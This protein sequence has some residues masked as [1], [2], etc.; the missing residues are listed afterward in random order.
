M[1]INNMSCDMEEI[2]SVDDLEAIFEDLLEQ[3]NKLV[4]SKWRINDMSTFKHWLISFGDWDN[5]YVEIPSHETLS[6][7]AEILDW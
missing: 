5:N 4:V 3:H 2:M 6:G 1:E 7:H